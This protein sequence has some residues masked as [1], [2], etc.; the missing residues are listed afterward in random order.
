MAKRRLK[1]HFIEYEWCK[2]WGIWVRFC[3][4]QMLA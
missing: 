2:G 3:P 4:K 1:Q